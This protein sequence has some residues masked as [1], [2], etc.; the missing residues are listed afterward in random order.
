MQ[1]DRWKEIGDFAGLAAETGPEERE[2]ILAARPD[3][4]EEIESLLQYMDSGFGPLDSDPLLPLGDSFAGRAIGPYEVIRE[5]GQGGMGTVLLARRANVEFEQKVAI[6]LARIAFQSEFFVRRFL[7]EQRILARLEHPNIAR[8]LDGG[9]TAD[10]TPYLV[11]QYV[12]GEA[13]DG[14]CTARGLGFTERIQLFLKVCEAVQFAHENLVV[15]RDLKPSNIL[16]TPAGEPMLLDF[17]T[18]R[19]VQAGESSGA[20]RTALPMM[21]L[22]YASPEQVGGLAGSTR[23]DVYSLCMVL[24]EL[25]TGQ[26]AYQGGREPGAAMIRAILEADVVQPSKRGV[27]EA[28]GDLDAILL[29]GLDRNP[30]RRYGTAAQLADDLRRFLLREPVRARK[31]TWRYRAGKFFSRHRAAVVAAAGVVV[32][33]TFATAL[34]IRQARIA[35]GERVKAERER[36]TAEE[37]AK[38]VERLLGAS[39]EG[40]MSPLAARGNNLRV[41]EIIDDAAKTVGQEFKEKPDVEAGLRSTIG[42]TY[43]ALGDYTKAKEHVER[44]VELSQRLYGDGSVGAIRALTARGRLRMGIGDWLGARQ[45]LGKSLEVSLRHGNANLSFLL[46]LLGEATFRVGDRKAARRHFEDALAEMRKQ[47]GTNHLTTA[48]MINNLGVVAEED[49]ENALAERNFEEAARVMRALPGPPPNLLFP[50]IGLQRAHF[51]RG[52]YPK[53]KAVCEEAYRVASANGGERN[54]GTASAMS[55]LALVKAHLREPDAELTIRKAVAVQRA[56]YPPGH[57]EIGRGLTHLGRVLL[58][59]GQS[60]EAERSLRE[61]LRIMRKTFPKN[62]WRTAEAQAFLGVAVISQGRHDQGLA[63]LEEGIREMEAV[64]PAS[65]PRVLEARRLRPSN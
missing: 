23:S 43:M 52:E 25:L 39:R 22:R 61:A 7:E 3:L 21:T 28:S 31:P 29:K 44:S 42:G 36:A 15:H 33:L 65:H 4:R 18:A 1:S 19:L 56:V 59:R 12:E 53:A 24:Y 2:A 48:T 37:V 26:W 16:V 30:E 9:V 55:Q 62:N 10:G 47:F 41:V 35:E 32:A 27:P 57:F 46:S 17:G 63:A 51:Y 54:R 45:D 13:L 64:L 34:S 5:L 8:L 38:F 6:K 49:G 14:W 40:E 60:K 58:M 20:T 11:I 50:L